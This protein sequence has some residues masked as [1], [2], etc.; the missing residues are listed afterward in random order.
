MARNVEKVKSVVMSFIS[1][2]SS[3]ELPHNPLSGCYSIKLFWDCTCL[4]PLEL[5]IRLNKAFHFMCP[6]TANGYSV[7]LKILY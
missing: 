5:T 7:D 2:R 4:Y 1:S 3:S 6:T